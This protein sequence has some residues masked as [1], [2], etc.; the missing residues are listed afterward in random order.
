MKDFSTSW[1]TDHNK[2]FSSY[3]DKGSDHKSYKSCYE[4][5]KPLEVCGFKVY[6]GSCSSPVV[7]DAE[8]YI[9]FDHSIGL[10]S[11]MPWERKVDQILFL[12]QDMRA[13]SNPEKFKKLVEW[14]AEQV[15]SG[16][17]LHAGCIG[18]HGRT[19][20]FLA[21]LVTVMSGEKDSISYVRNNYCKKAVESQ[22]QVKFLVDHFGVTLAASTKSLHVYSD[23][24]VGNTWSKKVLQK[25]TSGEESYSPVTSSKCIWRANRLPL[26]NPK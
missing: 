20:T 1:S 8:V 6:G 23:G 22:E 21:A 5:H 15:A 24:F 14:S 19:G 17:K 3:L 11:V 12:V 13:P 9:G 25:S 16:K 10:I 4:S 26:D 7:K 2:K 18:G